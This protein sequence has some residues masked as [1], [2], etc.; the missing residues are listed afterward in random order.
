[1][2]RTQ[3]NFQSHAVWNLSLLPDWEPVTAGRQLVLG[4]LAVQSKPPASI[5]TPPITATEEKQASS[6]DFPGD[7]GAAVRDASKRRCHLQGKPAPGGRWG[8]AAPQV[9]RPSQ[10]PPPGRPATH[11]STASCWPLPTVLAVRGIFK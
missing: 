5:P 6:C 9:H 7:H 8:R 10:T 4:V 1:M 3:V 2:F 11:P